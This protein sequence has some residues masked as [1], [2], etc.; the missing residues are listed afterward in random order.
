MFRDLA[1]FLNPRVL[2]LLL[3]YPSIPRPAS[4]IPIRLHPDAISSLQEASEAY[5]TELFEMANLCTI[6]AKRVALMPK[7]LQLVQRIVWIVK[8]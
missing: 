5:L 1:D 7:N 2:V 3:N 8:I 4:P 6:H